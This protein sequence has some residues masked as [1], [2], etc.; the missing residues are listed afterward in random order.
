MFKSHVR[1]NPLTEVGDWPPSIVKPVTSPGIS[2]V[3]TT[4]VA[5]LVVTLKV[6]V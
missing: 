2:F 3:K 6:M 5:V 4:P 1:V